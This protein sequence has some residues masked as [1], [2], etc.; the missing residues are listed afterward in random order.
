MDNVS[1]ATDPT[2][3]L[4]NIQTDN[5][6][7]DIVKQETATFQQLLS[8]MLLSDLNLTTNQSSDMTSLLSPLMLL[9]EQLQSQQ[10]TSQLLTSSTAGT[11]SSAANFS[12]NKQNNYYPVQGT[13]T[14]DFHPGHTGVDLAVDTGTP[15]HSTINGKVIYAGWNDQGYGNLVIV[16]NGDYKTYY[17][18]LSE[19]PVS[20]GQTIQ[21][22]EVIGLSGS[23]G[24]STGPHVHYEVRK[25]NVP[26]N[27]ATFNPSNI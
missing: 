11:D 18:H 23:T 22:G 10:I 9:L 17:A 27:P 1:I 15:V 13:L 20:V 19:I 4:S 14:Q 25:D 26:I 8:C 16:Q 7:P 6:Y 21:Q 12:I 2:V 5:T 3:S 24:N